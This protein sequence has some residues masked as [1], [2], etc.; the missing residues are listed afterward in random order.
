MREVIGT[1]V[2]YRYELENEEV[3]DIP[4]EICDIHLNTYHFEESWNENMY[5]E[6]SLLPLDDE[7]IKLGIHTEEFNDVSL[8]LIFKP[9]EKG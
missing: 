6:V 5:V 3:V 1:K 9:Y 7:Y 2:L 8:G 4:C